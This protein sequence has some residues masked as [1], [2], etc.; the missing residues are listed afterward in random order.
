MA[1]EAPDSS[2]HRARARCGI[3]FACLL[4]VRA[5]IGEARLGSSQDLQDQPAGTGSIHGVVLDSR[6]GSPVHRVSVRLQSSNRMAITDDDGRFV[7]EAVPEGEQ[8]LYISAV[9]FILV[10]R[11]VTVVAEQRLDITIALAEGTGTYSETVDVRAT[12][13][14]RRE[15]TVAADQT[16]GGV[17]L[18]QLA[19]LITNDPLRAVQVLPSV[20]ASDDLRSEFA[21]RGAGLAQMNFTFEGIATPFLLHTV[22]Q[23]HDSGSVAMVSGDVVADISVLSGSYPQRFGNRTGAEI[24]FRLRDGSRDRAQTHLS[25]SAIDASGVTEGPVGGSKRGSWLLSV[26]KSYLDLLVD[27]L[28]PNQNISFAFADVQSKV[29][30]DV[31][32]RQQLQVAFTGGRSRLERSP[33]GL[34]AGNLRDADNQGAIAVATWRYLRSSR[35]V[36]TQRF[37]ASENRFN[38][39]SRDG[40]A[41][42]GGDGHELLGRSDF[43]FVAARGLTLEGGGEVRWSSARA[44]EQRLAGGRFQSRENYD[45]SSVAGSTYV[46]TRF[47][48]ASG[49]ALTPGLRVD[50]HTL[51]QRTSVSPWLQGLLPLS[52]RL[53]LRAGGGIYRQEP[54]FA[55]QLGVRGSP[56]LAAERAYHADVGIE[57]RFS[58]DARWQITAYDREDRDQLRLPDAELRLVPAPPAG[59]VLVNPSL[60][61]RWTNAA[62]GHARGVEWL[63]R[64]HSVNGLSGWIS[65]ALGFARYHDRAT[66]ETFWGDFDQRHTVNVYGNYRVSDRTSVG[67]RFR[68]GS[69]FPVTGYW[70]EREGVYFLGTSRNTVRIPA[71]SRLDLRA[72]RTF[73]WDRTRLT[74][75][76]EAVNLLNQRNVRFQLPTVNRR[77]FEATGLFENMI[78]LVPSVGMLLEF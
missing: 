22:Q 4:W 55:E 15:A 64:Q 75:F 50:H 25:V 60:T 5:G 3:L 23:V 30:Y 16:L 21:I 78:P 53:T 51:S 49:W 35:L 63:V 9:D 39:T 26:R 76:V 59:S 41:L 74:L 52:P 20:A 36:A 65:Y 1:R 67:A 6:N 12:I 58:T 68:A 37:A 72:N 19:G 33:D 7:F 70:A 8:E 17:E 13:P 61:S 56:R 42:D 45:G 54:G 48:A 66:G 43:A 57:G 11:R 34:G 14:T 77:T 24:G 69:N 38:N 71:Y 2:R 62:D 27:R 29:V 44:Q 47:T 28:Y 32:P 46:Q 18:Q 40:A 10:K 73:T 31:T